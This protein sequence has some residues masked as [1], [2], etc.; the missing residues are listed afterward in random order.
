MVRVVIT[1]VGSLGDLHPYVA[2]AAGMQSRG[3]DV[4]I[5]TSPCYQR[6]IE[7]M[8]LEFW[9]LRPDMDWLSDAEM[10]RRLSHTRF[11]LIRVGRDLLMPALRQSYQD[12]LAAAEGAD[13]L[14]AMQA[15]YA[16]RLVAEKT[17]IPWASAVHIPLGF[18]SAHDP[19]VLEIAPF[20][21]R[22]LRFLGPVFW[23]SLFWAGKRA[24]RFLARPW[25]QLRA[26]LGLPPTTEG[27]PLADSFSPRLVLGLFSRSLA[28]KQPDWPAQTVVTGMPL[29]DGGSRL[30]ASLDRFLDDGPRAIVF[31]LGSAIS[32]NAGRFYE[33]SAAC[34]KLIGRRAVIVVG[35]GNRDHLR[36][37]TADIMTVEYAP[38]NELFPRVAVS[39]HHGGVGTTGLAL[40]S[41]RPMLVVP[42]AWDQPDN[43]DRVRRLGV[44]RTIPRRQYTPE[45]A[46]QELQHLLNN[47]VYSQ[48]ATEVGR[49][50]RQETGVEAAC[51]ALESV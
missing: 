8:G 39:V 24:S 32:M 12:T 19:P 9:P 26:E 50:V 41:G 28:D 31:T 20:L 42:F 3:H 11:G 21:S 49:H 51:D 10:M 38:F 43:A 27:N 45:R 44:A 18:F 36:S 4:A 23:R 14:I 1:T 2:V 34:A 25:Y 37:P 35:R 7:S 6:K 40:W 29:Y 5:A 13:L 46:A 33:L 30:S 48:R 22:K 15:T 47:P 16:T 17:G